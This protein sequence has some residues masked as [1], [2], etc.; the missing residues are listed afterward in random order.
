MFIRRKRI[1]VVLS[2]LLVFPATVWAV[3][4]QGVS[5]NVRSYSRVTGKTVY[6]GDIADIK[7]VSR[8]LDR[9]RHLEITRSP[10]PGRKR[11]ITGTMI[12]AKLRKS[13]PSLSRL[14]NVTLPDA[15]V[16]ERDYQVISEADMKK[17]FYSYIEK[18]A[19][20]RSFR[21]SD[22]RM[23]GNE[24]IATGPLRY[25][26]DDRNA[27][28]LEGRVTLTV[29]VTVPSERTAKIYLS[30]WV[31]I[32]QQIVCA[33]RDIARG[34]L[35]GKSDLRFEKKNLSRLPDGVLNNLDRAAGNIA[36][37]HIEKGQYLRTSLIEN[38]P[39]VRKGEVV[40]MIAHSGLLTVTTMGISKENGSL[41]DQ[42][43]VENEQSNKNVRA[44][45]VDKNTVEVLF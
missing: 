21:I 28:D 35:I 45:V 44:R 20:G 25:A 23:K 26:I 36:R 30:G 42:I 4:N 38:P 9:V 2:V 13:F 39:M 15:L 40:K 37:T 41:G 7:G 1:L 10:R 18:T 27:L 24:K 22:F 34:E 5:I 11:R 19:Q 31:D 6:F 12:E 3:G 16:V 8:D 14:A 29:N 43:T 32:Y 33:N 17:L